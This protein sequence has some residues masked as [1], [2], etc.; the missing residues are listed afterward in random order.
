MDELF[1]LFM[2]KGYPMYEYS[3]N[4]CCLVVD[5]DHSSLEYDDAAWEN[6]VKTEEDWT[7]MAQ[8]WNTTGTKDRDAHAPKKVGERNWN[9]SNSSVVSSPSSGYHRT[10]TEL[11]GK[12]FTLLSST[13][14][15]QCH[16]SSTTKLWSVVQPNTTKTPYKRNFTLKTNSALKQNLDFLAKKGLFQ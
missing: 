6:V 16:K 10:S 8:K 9:C 11:W 3:E 5:D 1:T 15:I 2:N 13:Y 4:L 7:W 14:Y 12:A